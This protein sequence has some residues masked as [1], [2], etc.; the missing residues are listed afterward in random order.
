MRPSRAILVAVLVVTIAATPSCTAMHRIERMDSP[1]PPLDFGRI[2][3]GDLV[4]VVMKDGR[5]AKFE[6]A[7]IDPN[8]VVSVDGEQF[9]RRDMARLDDDRLS[10]ERSVLVAA[11]IAAG[12]YLLGSLL[13]SIG[14]G[15][16]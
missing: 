9:L 5:K 10:L 8:L 15:G 2:E 7:S 11:A 13:G 3:V 16:R 6:V 14:F 4:S 12:V 1:A